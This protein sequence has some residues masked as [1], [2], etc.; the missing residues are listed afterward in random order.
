M[1]DIKRLKSQE[2]Q[3]NLHDIGKLIPCSTKLVDCADLV[4]AFKID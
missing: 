2:K 1:N 4:D 3:E